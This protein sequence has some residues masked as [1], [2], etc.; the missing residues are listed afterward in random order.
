MTAAFGVAPPP[1]V[2]AAS[3]LAGDAA[4]PRLVLVTLVR[5]VVPCD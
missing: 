1:F 5:P 3:L 4:R 2:V